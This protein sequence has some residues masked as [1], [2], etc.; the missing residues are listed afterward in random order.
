MKY[1]TLR[2]LDKDNFELEVLTSNT[3][4]KNVSITNAR[5]LCKQMGATEVEIYESD[6]VGN[7]SDFIKTVSIKY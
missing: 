2:F 1:F 4:L 6:R 7:I 3:K 5:S